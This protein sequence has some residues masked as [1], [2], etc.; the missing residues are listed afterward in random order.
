MNRSV[1]ANYTL[2]N[3]IDCSA[4]INWN[5]GQGFSPVAVTYNGRFTG[6]LKGKNYNITNLYIN[7]A[8]YVGLF[9]YTGTSSN[10]TNFSIINANYNGT[11]Y[12]G[13]IVAYNYGA[14]SYVYFK[15]NITGTSG[16]LG[17]IVGVN[18]GPISYCYSYGKF[19]A[20]TSG[21]VGGSGEA[22][23]VFPFEEIFQKIRYECSENS[24]CNKDESCVNNK[25]IKWF[26]M[27]ILDF[28]SPVKVGE[29]FN[30]TFF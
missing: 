6:S 22:I 21:N 20:T 17:G 13:G 28:D 12:L 8:T 11:T 29:F 19:I 26:D 16:E 25:C 23:A 10:I 18:D 7:R 9:G 2:N 14:V 5:S 30:F 1:G 24:E 27:E 3:N 4:T 15:G